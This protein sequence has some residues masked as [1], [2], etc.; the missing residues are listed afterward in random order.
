MTAEGEM[1][2]HKSQFELGGT[3]QSLQ[4]LS[5]SSFSSDEKTPPKNTYGII[6]ST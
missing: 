4:Q 5:S 1:I 2:G 6:L 3:I